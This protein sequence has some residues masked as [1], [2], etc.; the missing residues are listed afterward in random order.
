MRSHP[1]IGFTGSYI[2]FLKIVNM[3]MMT[4]EGNEPDLKYFHVPNTAFIAKNLA[5]F[6]TLLITQLANTW[7][8]AIFISEA[9][10]IDV[11]IALTIIPLLI[12]LNQN[13]YLI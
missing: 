8:L 3:L 10:I 6:I 2:Q 1:Y 12:Y 9:L 4:P 7:A 11:V 13:M 5:S